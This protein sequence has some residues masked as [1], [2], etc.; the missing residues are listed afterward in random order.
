MEAGLVGQNDVQQATMAMEHPY[1]HPLALKCQ[2][3][4]CS[5]TDHGLVRFLP[6]HTA[7]SHAVKTIRSLVEGFRR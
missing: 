1:P 5:V 6:N 7:C 4:D 3:P 2:S